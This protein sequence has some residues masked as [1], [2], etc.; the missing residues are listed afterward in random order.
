MSEK[1]FTDLPGY[2]A[3]RQRRDAA[4][5]A[6]RAAHADAIQAAELTLPVGP[7]GTYT[8]DARRALAMQDEA[9]TVLTIAIGAANAALD[10]DRDA[11]LT[12]WQK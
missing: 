12:K 11:G 7:S 3:S 8:E 2:S 6:A 1:T 4:I 10:A 9:D 5:K